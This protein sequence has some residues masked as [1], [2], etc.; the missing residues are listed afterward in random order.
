SHPHKPQ[1]HLQGLGRNELGSSMTILA[2][3]TAGTF[4]GSYHTAVAATNKQ[5]L[6]SPRQGAQ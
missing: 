6:V 2:L 3:N 4:S 1:G 5:I